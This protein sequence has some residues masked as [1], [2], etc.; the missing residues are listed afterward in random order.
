M[1]VAKNTVASE[2]LIET[3]KGYIY[4]SVTSYDYKNDLIQFSVSGS[5][6]DEF[7]RFNSLEDALRVFA[8]L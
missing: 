1:I 7:G 6:G 3:A 8:S 5:N 2:F 4:K